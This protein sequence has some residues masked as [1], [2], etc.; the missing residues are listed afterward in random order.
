M[1]LASAEVKRLLAHG[2]RSNA[3]VEGIVLASRTLA[4]QSGAGD[5]NR[6]AIGGTLGDHAGSARVA[7]AVPKRQ[8]KRSVD[9]NRVKR[10]LRETFRQHQV[11]DADIDILVTL[12]GVPKLAAAKTVKRQVRKSIQLAA[13]AL[14]TKLAAGNGSR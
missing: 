7:L 2:R 8:L 6:P 3:A 1:R 10:I 12:N 5:N 11:R 13:T 4:R 14:F 9:S